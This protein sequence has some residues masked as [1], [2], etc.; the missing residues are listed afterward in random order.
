MYWPGLFN[1]SKISRQGGLP[2]PAGTAPRPDHCDPAGRE[3]HLILL[4]GH[5][6]GIDER[7]MTYIDEEIS[8]AIM[9]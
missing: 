8:S 5:Y 1:M 3:D 6:E 2:V 4:C 7:A 9:F